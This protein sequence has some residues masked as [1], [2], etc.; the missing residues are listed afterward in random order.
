MPPHSVVSNSCFQRIVHGFRTI[1][2]FPRPFDGFAGRFGICRDL[3]FCGNAFTGIGS[4]GGSF[5]H[6]AFGSF[7][8]RPY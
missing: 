6:N 2:F 3:S 1:R 7:E 4:L 8:S 5:L